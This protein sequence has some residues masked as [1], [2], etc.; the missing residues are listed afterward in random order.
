MVRHNF[1]IVD[2]SDYSMDLL[3]R[4]TTTMRSESPPPATAPK[5]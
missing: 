5:S 1:V 3:M 2:Y 4:T